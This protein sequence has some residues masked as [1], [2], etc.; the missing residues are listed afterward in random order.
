M[1]RETAGL[2]FQSVGL[3]WTVNNLT[4][5]SGGRWQVGG[6]DIT[7]QHPALPAFITTQ[8]EVSRGIKHFIQKILLISSVTWIGRIMCIE[9]LDKSYIQHSLFTFL[10][11]IFQHNAVSDYHVI[12]QVDMIKSDIP[13]SPPTTP[14]PSCCPCVHLTKY[15]K[16]P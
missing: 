6:G 7:T 11:N 8:A 1:E 15:E 4:F 9:I 16:R 3:D 5:S 12:Y 2:C 10:R 13:P 14:T